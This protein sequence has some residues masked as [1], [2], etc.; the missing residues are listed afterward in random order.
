MLPAEGVYTLHIVAVRDGQT[1]TS[2]GVTVT[3]VADLPTISNIDFT[4]GSVSGKP[5]TNPAYGFPTFNTWVLMR[6]YAPYVGQY[7]GIVDITGSFK[8]NSL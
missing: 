4:S 6:T 1:S 3:A 7:R 8:V 5:V 2:H